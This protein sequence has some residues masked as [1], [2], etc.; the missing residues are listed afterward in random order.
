MQESRLH[1][2]ST[3]SVLNTVNWR[4]VTVA[5]YEIRG[6]LTGGWYLGLR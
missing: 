5:R 2:S 6:F 1:L 3:V 4:C